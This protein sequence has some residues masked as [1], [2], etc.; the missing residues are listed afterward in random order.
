VNAKITTLVALLLTASLGGCLATPRSMRMEQDFDEMKRRLAGLERNVASMRSDQTGAENDRL[1]SAVRRQADLQANL[2]ALRVE[3]QTV[4]GRL[5][6]VAR[7][8]QDLRQELDLIQQDM[9]LKLNSIEDRLQKIEMSPGAAQATQPAAVPQSPKGL[10]EEGLRLIQKENNLAAGRQVLEDFLR[11]Y[12][13]DELAVNAMYWI[14]ETYYGEKKYENAI[15]QFQDVIQKFGDHPKVASAL[16]K[17]GLSFKALGDTKNA[18]VL[19][20][21]VVELFPLSDEAKTAKQR[22][23]EWK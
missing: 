15:L 17:Q 9:G 21:R 4:K 11:K 14:G 6:D 13:Q 8:P 3:L 16:L 7:Q 23:A 19:L 18:K 1:D 12:P 10:Y 2:D 5:D 22:L 20:Q